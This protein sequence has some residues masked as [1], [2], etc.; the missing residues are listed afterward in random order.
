[1]RVLG[2]R[3]IAILGWITGMLEQDWCWESR[4]PLAC[5]M[6][7]VSRSRWWVAAMG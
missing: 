7:S 5:S 3:W 6:L 4:Y 1:M 2:F